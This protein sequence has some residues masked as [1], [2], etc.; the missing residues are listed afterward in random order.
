MNFSRRRI[1]MRLFAAHQRYKILCRILEFLFDLATVRPFRTSEINHQT[2]G[3][4]TDI[5]SIVHTFLYTLTPLAVLISV[6]SIV[7]LKFV[8]V[9]RIVLAHTVPTLALVSANS[10]QKEPRIDSPDLLHFSEITEPIYDDAFLF[11]MCI[12]YPRNDLVDPVARPVLPACVSML[13]EYSS[14]SFLTFSNRLTSFFNFRADVIRYLER[15]EVERCLRKDIP[16]GAAATSKRP[17]QPNHQVGSTAIDNR[18]S[19]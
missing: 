10:N 3:V 1:T 17:G 18:P 4:V 11:N 15:T 16:H 14:P 6:S 2:L 13:L 12:I 9:A 5:I 19:F 7:V 8:L